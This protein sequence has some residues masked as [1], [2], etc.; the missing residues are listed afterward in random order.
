MQLTL[1]LDLLP[2]IG[3]QHYNILQKEAECTIFAKTFCTDALKRFQFS[4]NAHLVDE[5]FENVFAYLNLLGLFKS[6]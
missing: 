1:F 2:V 3:L 5:N 4:W 6:A